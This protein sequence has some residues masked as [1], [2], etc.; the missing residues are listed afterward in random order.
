M[1][2]SAPA[3]LEIDRVK[4]GGMDANEH[5]TKPWRGLCARRSARC[6]RVHRSVKGRTLAWQNLNSHVFEAASEP[7]DKVQVSP[8]SSSRSH[9]CLPDTKTRPAHQG[10]STAWS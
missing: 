9:D 8:F 7:A 6:L 4:A 10:T 5:F 1:I 3:R 2:F